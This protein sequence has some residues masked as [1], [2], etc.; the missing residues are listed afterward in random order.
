MRKTPRSYRAKIRVR[1]S[2]TKKI[3]ENTFQIQILF[4]Y[5]SLNKV[6]F[7]GSTVTGRRI[8]EAAAKS[9]LKRVTLELGGKSPAIVFDDADIGKAASEVASSVFSNCGQVCCCCSRVFVHED[10]HDRFVDKL[11]ELAE[12]RVVGCPFDRKSESGC[13][14]SRAQFE[15]VLGYVAVGRQEG[16]SCLTGGER[17]AEKGFFMRPTIFTDVTDDM[18]IAKEEVIVLWVNLFALNF[19]SKLGMITFICLKIKFSIFASFLIFH[20]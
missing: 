11:K 2:P 19:E 17:M 9:N 20:F 10:V 1:S 6:A 13:L 16:A 4:K 8:Q 5:T 12:R 14:I 18:T 7:T 15:K 3:F